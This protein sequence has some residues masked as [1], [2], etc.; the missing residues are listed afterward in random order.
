MKV[1]FSYEDGWSGGRWLFDGMYR[2]AFEGSQGVDPFPRPGMTG[3]IIG[4]TGQH[5]IVVSE[6]TR[7]I[8]GIDH[9]HGHQYPWEYKEPTFLIGGCPIPTPA[10]LI[11]DSG[12]TILLEVV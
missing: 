9:D 2:T 5:P 1:R 8:R 4:P 11:W 12:Y 3:E 7:T 6:K 10:H